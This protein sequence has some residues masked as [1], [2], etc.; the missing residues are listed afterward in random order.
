M[1]LLPRAGLTTGFLLL[2]TQALAQDT[3]LPAPFLEAWPVLGLL[4]GT[5]SVLLAAEVVKSAVQWL[6]VRLQRQMMDVPHWMIHGM[7]LILS[8]GVGWLFIAEGRLDADPVFSSLGWPINWLIFTIAVFWRAGG[9][10]DEEIEQAQEL[11]RAR[12]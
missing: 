5:A 7:N 3:G 2:T 10:R 8:A 4:L 9:K 1:K 11:A 6:K 12:K